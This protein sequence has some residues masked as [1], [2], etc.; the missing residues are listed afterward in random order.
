MKF[1]EIRGYVLTS[2]GAKYNASS[3]VLNALEESNLCI[4]NTSKQRV[5][6][7]KTRADEGANNMVTRVYI[8]KTP[9]TGDVSDLEIKCTT[10]PS[11]LIIHGH[12]P[13]HYN[14]EITNGVRASND[15]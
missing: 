4:G 1:V 13:I 3:F 11:D 12:C 8:K 5:A 6:I 14:T 2:F 9:N 15:R 7:V 10:E